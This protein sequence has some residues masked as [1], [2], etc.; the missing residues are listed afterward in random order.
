VAKRKESSSS[1]KKVFVETFD[2]RTVPGYVTP[3]QLGRA[4]GLELLNVNGEVEQMELERVRTVYF[5]N[6]FQEKFVP[7]RKS[8]LS[9][10][11][12]DGLWVRVK[13]RDEETLEGV[14]TNDLVALLDRGVNLVPP[15]P[16]TN[17]TRIF[18]PRPAIVEM[19]VLGVVGIARRTARKAAE[20]QPTLFNE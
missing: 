6:D 5:V 7:E 19:T 2:G 1:H 4:E 17:C 15:D 18:I 3:S 11:K 9:R 12:L 8:F 10:P 14:V 13:Y 16:G 20:G